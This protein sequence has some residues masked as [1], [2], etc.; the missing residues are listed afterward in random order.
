MD[1]VLCMKC[2]FQ[3]SSA[4]LGFCTTT[5]LRKLMSCF[6]IAFERDEDDLSGNSLFDVAVDRD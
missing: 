4:S 3:G 5:Q 1:E 6:L 2:Y